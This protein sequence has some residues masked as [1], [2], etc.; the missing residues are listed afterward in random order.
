MGQS[1]KEQGNEDV[2]DKEMR[3]KHKG[4]IMFGELQ[5]AGAGVG[6]H[7]GREEAEEEGTKWGLGIGTRS[8]GL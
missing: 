2:P 6:E 8:L 4:V 1:S 5:M 7:M 3:G